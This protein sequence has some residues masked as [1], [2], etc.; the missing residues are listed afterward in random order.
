MLDGSIAYG[1]PGGKA[2]RE[3]VEEAA[4]EAGCEDF[5][6]QLDN[7]L[8]T[9]VSKSSLSGVSLPFSYSFWD[10]MFQDIDWLHVVGSKTKIVDRQSVD[11][12]T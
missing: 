6:A 11:K 2:T 8:D 4:R 10:P 7:G 1:K 5:I 12:E 9:P 3:E